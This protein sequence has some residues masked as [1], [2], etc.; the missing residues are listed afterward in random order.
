MLSGNLTGRRIS[1]AVGA[2]AVMIAA[3]PAPAQ[4]VE[5]K[6]AWVRGTV[7]G[8][9]VSGAFMDIT[10]RT[11]ARLVAASSPAIKDVQIHNMKVEGGIM[12]MYQV[13]GVGLPAGTTVKL[14]PGGYHVMLM[15]LRQPL[16]QGQRI[17][18]KLT[19]E[20]ADKQR[21]T[22]DVQAKVRDVKGEAQKHAH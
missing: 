7:A 1:L 14:A 12:K 6:N 22:I 21:E 17:P 20:R 3:Q 4:T 9:S 10:S 5:V 2:M 19:F 18:L 16:A 11:P 13:D 15:N 8:Q